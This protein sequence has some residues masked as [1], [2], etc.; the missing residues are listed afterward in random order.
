MY[1]LDNAQNK[2]FYKTKE[3]IFALGHHEVS[4]SFPR[5][6]F[7]FEE[8]L[9][10]RL[11]VADQVLFQFINTVTVLSLNKNKH[12]CSQATFFFFF[13]QSLNNYLF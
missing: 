4:M 5:W 11:V 3:V 1:I 10:L 8:L 7:C 6:C 9:K 13:L 2:N 12:H